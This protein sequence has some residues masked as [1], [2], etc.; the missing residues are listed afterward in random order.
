MSDENNTEQTAKLEELFGSAEADAA[1]A[2]KP[3]PTEPETP[4]A[5]AAAAPPVATAELP[6]AEPAWLHH[7]TEPRPLRTTPRVRWAGVIWGLIFAATGAFTA[8][9]L[10]AQDRRAAFSHWILTL[11]GG[12]WVI[13]GAVA[14]GTL[15]LV[16]GLIEGLKAATRRA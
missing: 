15:L 14:I 10:L 4:A 2:T 9:T 11:G 8:W 1:A 6:E 3:M 13:V 7:R 5:S 12:G 16:I